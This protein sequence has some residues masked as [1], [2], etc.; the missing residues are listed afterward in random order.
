LARQRRVRV[1]LR[2]LSQ[3]GEGFAPLCREVNQACLPPFCGGSRSEEARPPAFD[4][5]PAS[6]VNYL[7]NHDQI[8]NSA[9]GLRLHEQT[10]AGRYKAITA[11]LLLMPGTPLIFQGQE[12]GAAYCF[13]RAV[14]KDSR[15]GTRR[16][17][18]PGTHAA[19][20][21]CRDRPARSQDQLAG[22]DH[23]RSGSIHHYAQHTRRG[24]RP[25]AC[26]GR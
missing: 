13:D 8:A 26:N 7:E 18:S 23:P 17:V 19:I 25:S 1:S 11:L 20:Q 5:K 4:L 14:G 2:S 3:R 21:A 6:F 22:R 24:C 16:R 10:S 9:Y 15:S 12:Y